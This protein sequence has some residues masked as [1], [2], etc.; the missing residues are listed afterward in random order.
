LHLSRKCKE[1]WELYTGQ[2]VIQWIAGQPLSL[3]L[4]NPFGPLTS[5]PL[6]KQLSRGQPYRVD[7]FIQYFEQPVPGVVDANIYLLD[8]S[9]YLLYL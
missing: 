1:S 8:L 9:V 4:N 7:N 2:N 3:L 5:C 6:D